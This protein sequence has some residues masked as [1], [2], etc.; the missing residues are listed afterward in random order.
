M[1]NL[2]RL[3]KT[4]IHPKKRLGHGYGSGKGG[5]TSSRGQKGQKSRTKLPLWFEGGQLPQI[6]RFPF[7]RGKSRFDSLKYKPI[8]INLSA[9]DQ[10]FKAGAEV[11]A[12]TLVSEGL[13]KTGE[14]KIRPIKILGRGSLTH[15][16]EVKL[17]ASKLAKA[18]IEAAGGKVIL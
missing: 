10:K 8:E 12:K 16:L 11:T 15:A 14:L 2:N 18:K 9:L 1:I 7:I 13:V 17:P 6:R 3:P 5:H 4:T